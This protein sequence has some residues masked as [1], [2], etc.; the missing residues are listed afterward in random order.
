MQVESPVE[1]ETMT[2]KELATY[3][4]QVRPHHARAAH[5]PLSFAAREVLRRLAVPDATCD[6]MGDC[7]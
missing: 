2:A 6:P 3:F 4:Q 1:L 5:F 7:F